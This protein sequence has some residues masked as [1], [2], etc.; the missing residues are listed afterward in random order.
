MNVASL[1]TL[2]STVGIWLYFRA[3]ADCS[4]RGR[5]PSLLAAWHRSRRRDGFSVDSDRA[6][7]ESRRILPYAGRFSHLWPSQRYRVPCCH[8]LSP[9]TVSSSLVTVGTVLSHSSLIVPIARFSGR[10]TALRVWGGGCLQ[11]FAPGHHSS[12]HDVRRKAGGV[13]VL[14]RYPLALGFWNTLH[15]RAELHVLLDGQPGKQRRLLKDYAPF[16]TR[17][18]DRFPSASTSLS[19]AG[20]K[21]ATMFSKIDLP[22]HW[23]PAGGRIQQCRHPTRCLTGQAF[24][25]ACYQAIRSRP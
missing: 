2:Q 9:P 15:L 19:D 3:T 8:S 6:F 23:G 7:T 25:G 11:I 13:K 5:D 4:V 18:G 14:L 21:P 22:P 1:N 12:L 16:R 24:G 10:R 20:I 17:R